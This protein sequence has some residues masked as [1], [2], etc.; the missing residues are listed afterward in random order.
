MTTNVALVEKRPTLT[1]IVQMSFSSILIDLLI[2]GRR[3]RMVTTSEQCGLHNR[4]CV[5]R[6]VFGQRLVRVGG[7]LAEESRSSY[8]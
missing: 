3:G 6:L 8:N 2:T 7:P 4:V 1:S 5:C